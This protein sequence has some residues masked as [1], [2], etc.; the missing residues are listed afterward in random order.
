MPDLADGESME[1]QGSARTPYIVKN[2]AGVFSCSCMAWKNQS[3]PI[4]SRTCKHIRFIRGDAAEQARLGSVAVPVTPVA[5]KELVAPPLL[6]AHAWDNEQDL[7]SWWISELCCIQHN[8]LYV[9]I[10]VM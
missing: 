1:V 5:N 8:S 10:T 7:S 4:D 6:L 3:L 9:F 2:I